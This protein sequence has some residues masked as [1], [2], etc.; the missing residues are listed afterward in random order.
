VAEVIEGTVNYSVKELL[1]RVD[2]KIDL[3][4]DKL[5]S[6]ADQK[7]VT[8]LVVRVEKLESSSIRLSGAWA[9]LGIT[10]SVLAG[11]AGLCV[12]VAAFI[13]N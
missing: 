1:A 9:T 5:D 3:L 13:L 4:G 2:L 10:A 12:G 8:A 7:D 6:K 11:I